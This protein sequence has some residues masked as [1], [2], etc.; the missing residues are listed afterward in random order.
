MSTI[1]TM[2]DLFAG[3]G[4]LTAGFRA[5][6]DGDIKFEP[7]AAVELDTL[8]A[9]TYAANHG[10]HVFVGDINDWL[11]TDIPEVDIVLGGPPC[12]G[13]SALGNRDP[14]DPRNRLWEAYVE[15]V[16]RVQPLYF[17]LENVPQFL[18]SGQFAQLE[19]ALDRGG[20]LEDYELEAYQLNAAEYGTP[21]LRRR[22]IVLGRR[23]DLAALG[24]PEPTT[25]QSQPTVRQAFKGLR[26]LVRRVELPDRKRLFGDD[27]VAGPYKSAEL[28]LTRRF[29][30]IS[31]DR[32]EEIP[33][34][35]NRFDIPD[36]LLP[37]CWKNH[38]SGSG[39]VM[40][41]L[42]WNRPSVTIRTEFFK[43][44]KGRYLH[45][46]EHRSITHLEASRIQGFP[47]NYLWHGSKTAIA[48]QIG[49]A[50]PVP[51]AAAIATHIR[52]TGLV[53]RREVLS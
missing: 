19:R 33:P 7:V 17:V 47:D 48:R 44:E 2:I 39:D 10:D 52:T 51:L 25:P 27:Q 49:N 15:T 9:A 41:R 22:A 1:Y 30:Q 50:V 36:H 26:R 14:A 23:K 45:P 12:Q 35:G 37:R 42:H 31:L 32:F 8:A 3:S 43:P 11:A 18:R 6:S 16:R 53:N 13:F 20:P 21:Q 5:A 38:R 4:G 40:G 46:T 24:K 34:G 28:H 29:Q